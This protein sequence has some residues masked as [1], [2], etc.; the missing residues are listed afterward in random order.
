MEKVGKDIKGAIRKQ[1]SNKNIQY[2]DPKQIT[3]NPTL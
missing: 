3:E 2:H 1:K